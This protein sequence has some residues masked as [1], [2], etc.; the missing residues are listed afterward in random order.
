MSSPSESIA[1]CKIHNSW[2]FWYKSY[3]CVHIVAFCDEWC[4]FFMKW[5]SVS[6]YPS[7][8]P[9]IVYWFQNCD[10]KLTCECTTQTH[11]W[12]GIKVLGESK[13][14]F[15]NNRYLHAGTI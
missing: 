1:N 2:K 3:N 6:T 5:Q 15:T 10:I 9:C 4:I 13:D 8:Q 7:P 12:H 11:T 14:K